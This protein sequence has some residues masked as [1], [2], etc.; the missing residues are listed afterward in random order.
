MRHFWTPPVDAGLLDT[1]LIVQGL[2]LMQRD[3]TGS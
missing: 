2:V 3:K 1:E